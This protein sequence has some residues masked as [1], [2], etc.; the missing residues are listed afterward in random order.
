MYFKNEYKWKLASQRVK[1]VSSHKS[2]ALTGDAMLTPAFSLLVKH[3]T[4]ILVTSAP[5]TYVLLYFCN[6]TLGLKL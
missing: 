2:T 1:Q 4:D 6:W 5:N 3:L